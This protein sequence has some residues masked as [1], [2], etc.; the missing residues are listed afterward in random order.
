MKAIQFHQHGGTDVLV[1]EEVPTPKPGPNQVLIRVRA[2]SINHL[3]IWVRNGIPAFPIPLPHIPG[4]DASGLVE[5]VGEGVTGFKRGDPVVISP[6]LSCFQCQACLSGDDN[7]CDQYSIL[8][9]GS[10][11]TYAEFTVVPARNLVSKPL[12]ITYEEAAAFPLVY[13]TSWHML[14]SRAHLTPGD[15]LLV[16]GAGSG[17]GSA[18]VQIGKLIGARVIGTVGSEEKLPKAK[19]LGVDLALNHS[20]EDI[21][22]K[23]MEFTDGRGVDVVFEHVGPASWQTSMNVLAKKG[24]IVT[25]GATTGPEVSIDLRFLYMKKLEI[26]GSIMGTRAELLRIS[27]L[28]SEKKLK[29]VIDSVHPLEEAE[30]AQDLMEQRKIFGKL[31]LLPPQ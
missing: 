17:I 8:G 13:L 23:V 27:Q 24:R 29:P 28:V 11:G 14:M 2:A 19:D 12:E 31:V 16:L 21:K 22:A 1:Y 18:A 3:D 25:C 9:A 30:A 5:E 6:G 7:L 15:D 26:L 4:S 10:K 20:E